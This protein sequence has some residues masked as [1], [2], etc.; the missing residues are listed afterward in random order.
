MKILQ[1]HYS[2]KNVRYQIV[3]CHMHSK[4][5]KIT[6]YH[7]CDK[8]VRW[9]LFIPVRK[10][11]CKSGNSHTST[12]RGDSRHNEK[13]NVRVEGGD[14]QYGIPLEAMRP[15]DQNRNQE[16]YSNWADS[17]RSFPKV[18]KKK[19][20]PLSELV[21]EVQ[22]A[23]VKRL[24]LRRAI[25]QYLAE[26]D[27]CHCR[28]CSNNGLAFMDGNECK[29]I[30]KPGTEGLACERG[31]EDEGQPGVIHGSWSCW[32]AWS[33]CSGGRRS[34]SRSCSN[35]IPQNGGQ[36]C[37]GEPTET[38]ECED[39]DLQHLKTMEPQCF[40]RTLPARQNCGT[41]PAL[42]NGYILDPK[43]IYLVGSRIQYTCTE[44]YHFVGL[45]TL[46]CTAGQTWSSRPGLCVVSR[47]RIESLANDVIA[48][49]LKQAYSI[50]ETVTLSCPEGRQLQ[51]E[52][53]TICDSSLNFSPN[54]AD[55]KC[56]PVSIQ[57]EHIPTQCK[58]WEKAS[59]GKCVCK[60]PFECG[61]SL[62]LCATAAEGS[63]KTSLLTV[64]KVHA[65][66]CVGKQFT[67]A[68]DS[69][70]NW[71]QRNTAGCTNCH[72]WETCDDQTDECRCKDSALCLTPGFNVC[73]R[74][75]EDATAAT[76]TMSECEAGLRRCKGEKVSVVSIQPCTS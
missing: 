39:Q 69:N 66:Q 3:R 33:L 58:L 76:Q 6:A 4:V 5:S 50:G 15:Y 54:P 57:Q 43:D 25:E 12:T 23:G 28:P 37:I 16:L 47:C 44:G 62:E 32:S 64:C 14:P 40:D 2:I 7:E 52:A 1:K 20:R 56:S 38:S 34:R 49:P 65:L 45:N 60:M 73:V 18:T 30:C 68:E 17:I 72:M 35:P 22:C 9:Y 75:G 24:Y 55:V 11:D 51:G 26:S 74:I 8:S 29:C 19:L 41:P 42:I 36:A 46:E 13:P 71:P 21:K 31:T 59:R 53:T 27:P 67:A 48:S 70:C 61:S 10:N 63:R